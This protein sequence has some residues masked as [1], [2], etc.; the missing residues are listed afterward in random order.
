MRFPKNFFWGGAIAANQAE[1][2]YNEDGKGMTAVDYTTGGAVDR[3][4]TV[5]YRTVE[6]EIIH[7]GRRETPPAGAK[8][9]I[10]RDS[11][12]PNHLAVDH[13]HRFKEDIRLFGEMGMKMFRMSIAWSRIFPNVNDEKPNRKADGFFPLVNSL[14]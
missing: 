12:Y 10:D 7:V 13:Y 4:R 3:F 6:G 2:A 1:G 8:L 5:T 14:I 11:Y 9:C